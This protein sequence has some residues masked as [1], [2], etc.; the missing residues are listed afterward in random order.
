MYIWDHEYKMYMRIHIHIKCVQIC[1]PMFNVTKAE[2]LQHSKLQHDKTNHNSNNKHLKQS[3]SWPNYCIFCLSLLG[4][5][6]QK[7]LSFKYLRNQFKTYERK[8]N[9]FLIETTIKNSE[10]F[11][12]RKNT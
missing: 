10:P 8:I 1:F 5:N 2:F 4:G 6:M 7:S 3:T 9:I 12:I 11:S